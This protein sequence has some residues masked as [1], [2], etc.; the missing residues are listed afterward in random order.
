MKLKILKKV[1]ERQGYKK[2]MIVQTDQSFGQELIDRGCAEE[3]GREV[4]TA[5]ELSMQEHLLSEEEGP[6]EGHD[7]EEKD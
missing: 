2:G 5:D 1:Q 7:N 6:V 3:V 4:V